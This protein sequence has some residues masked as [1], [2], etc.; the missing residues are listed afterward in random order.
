MAEG[1]RDGEAAAAGSRPHPA[2]PRGRG[3]APRR[4]RGW[5]EYRGQGR[6]GG[7][8]RGLGQGQTQ[9][10]PDDRVLLD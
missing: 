8:E 5:R 2:R 7:G 1:P 3:P 6:E 4:S 9:A 10:R